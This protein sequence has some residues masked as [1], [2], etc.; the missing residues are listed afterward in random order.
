MSTTT[1]RFTPPTCTL[2]IKGKNPLFRRTDRDLLKFQFQLRFDDPRLVTSKQVT[3]QG[4]R[5]DLEQL[6]KAVNDYIQEFLH[7]SFRS[8]TR[9]NTDLKTKNKFQNDLPCLQPQGLVNHELFFGSLKHDNNNHKIKLATLQLFDLVTA[10]EA[11][12]TQI[13]TL[14]ERQA[15]YKVISLWGGI[16][17]VT[18]A[19]VGIATVMLKLR[20]PQVSPQVASSPQSE[21]NAEIL[22]LDEIIPPQAPKTARQPTAKPKLTEPLDSAKKLPPPPAVDIPKPKPDI[23]DPADY[24][25]SD[26]A[27]QSGLNNSMKETPANR[28]A[29]STIAIPPNTER[30]IAK[31]DTNPDLAK[32]NTTSGSRTAIDSNSEDL[33]QSERDSNFAFNSSPPQTSQLQEVTAYFQEKWQPPAELKQSLEYRLL[34][35]GDGSIKRVIPL[36]K[37]AKLYLS[38]TN[39]PVNGESFISASESQPVIRL[40]LN[41]NGR[42]QAFIE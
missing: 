20:S 27:R 32:P 38:K 24:P 15:R 41:P 37:A 12:Q 11:Y 34:L 42:V 31:S 9:S 5:Q 23:P 4:D 26:V 22:E 33:A 3:I 36:G 40:L 21:P 2:E 7:A 25:L 39:I 30:A 13:A 29:E 28:Q 35:D 1:H 18:I 8:A 10:L 19:G 16:A 6:Q 17:A 14:P